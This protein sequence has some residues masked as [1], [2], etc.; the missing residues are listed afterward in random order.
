[1]IV[2]VL[3]LTVVTAAAASPALGG[4]FDKTG[5]GNPMTGVRRITSSPTGSCGQCHI[6][7]EGQGLKFAM[8]LWR[9]NDNGLCFECHKSE[10]MRESYPGRQIYE[11]SDHGTDPRF[12]WPGPTPPARRE[13]GGAGKCLNCHSPHGKEDRNGIIP[14]LLFAREEALCLTCHS[15]YPSTRDIAH[16]IRKPYSHPA[17][18]TADK[19]SSTEDGDPSRYS[20][21][22][23]YRHATCSDCHNAHAAFSDSL[24]PTAPTASNRNARVSR[25]RVINSAAGAVPQYDYRPANDFTTPVL[26]YE[27]CY[28]CHSSWTQL[29]PGRQDMARLFNTNNPSFHP[30]EG[31]G[32][33]LGI[34]PGAFVPGKTNAFSTIYCSDCHGSDDSQLRGPHGSQFP[35]ILRKSYEAHSTSRVVTREELCFICHS[36]DAYA[37]PLAPLS[38]QQASRFNPPVS[39]SGHALHVG[40]KNVP[41]YACHDSHGSTQFPALIVTGRNPGLTNFFATATGGTCMSTCHASRSYVIN[42]PR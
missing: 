37:N 18:L 30:V 4:V 9:E 15:G 12:A 25:V 24:P 28:K 33:N 39:P 21:V 32:K 2:R 23:G 29:P 36:F 38:Q 16:D 34:N 42:Y 3:F 35:N 5:H 27:I 19:H 8:G 10:N 6:E 1:M 20:Y 14:S 17:R 11:K 31:Q 26:E 22:G 13:L 7:K 41:C 40:Q